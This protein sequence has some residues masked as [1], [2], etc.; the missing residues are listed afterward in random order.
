MYGIDADKN[1]A[2]DILAWH[3]VTAVFIAAAE[4]S[5]CLGAETFGPIRDSP[6]STHSTEDCPGCNGQN[7]AGRRVSGSQVHIRDC[8]MMPLASKIDLQPMPVLLKKKASS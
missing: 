8:E 6:V 4:T 3:D 7:T 2:D 1:I 5:S